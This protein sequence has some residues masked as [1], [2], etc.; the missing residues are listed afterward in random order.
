MA[1]VYSRKALL[2]AFRY[3][4]CLYK[5]QTNHCFFVRDCLYTNELQFCRLRGQTWS[6]LGLEIFTSDYTIYFKVL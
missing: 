1:L 5:V 3:P 4:I 2:S 6:G